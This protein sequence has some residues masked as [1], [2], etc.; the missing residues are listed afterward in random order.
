MAATRRE[1]EQVGRGPRVRPAG[2]GPDLDLQLPVLL[3]LTRVRY[4][5]PR[6]RPAGPGPDHRRPWR[7]GRSCAGVASLRGKPKMSGGLGAVL[8]NRRALAVVEHH[9][10]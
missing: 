2:P 6:V 5:C 8:C 10:E 3:L 4:E 7:P 1:A 9:A